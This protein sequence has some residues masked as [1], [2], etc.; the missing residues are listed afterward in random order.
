MIALDT[1]VLVRWILRDDPAQSPKADE[2]LAEPF[3]M[4]T[5]VLTELGWALGSI[6]GM[7]RAEIARSVALLLRLPT[8]NIAHAAEVRWAVERFATR[9][10]WED[11]IHIATSVG[12]DAFGSF[13]KKLV[14]EVGANAPMTIA[15]LNP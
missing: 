15:D 14:R 5:S 11:L 6:A 7:T 3:F 4:S 9:G 13:E 8:A 2:I 12:A 10:D 1:N